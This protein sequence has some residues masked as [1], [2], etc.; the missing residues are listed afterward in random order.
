VV[1]AKLSSTTEKS[2]FG[3][4]AGLSIAGGVMM[5]TAG[6][7]TAAHLSLFPNMGGMI[8]S[9]QMTSAFML[10]S[11]WGIVCGI[12]TTIMGCLMYKIPSKIRTWGILVLIVSIASWFE[13]GGFVMGSILA[14][15]GGIIAISKGNNNNKLTP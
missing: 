6:A 8:M 9:Y 5:I 7:F 3:F 12:I 2:Q 15:I 13:L 11:L 14:T 4:P 1:A 10:F